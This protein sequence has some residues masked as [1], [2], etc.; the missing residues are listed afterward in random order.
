MKRTATKPTAEAVNATPAILVQI[1]GLLA[2]IGKDV[3]LLG[4]TH[5]RSRDARLVAQGIERACREIATRALDYAGVEQGEGIAAVPAAASAP[6]PIAAPAATAPLAPIPAAAS[7]P[8]HQQRGIIDRAPATPDA[9]RHPAPV[10]RQ[11]APSSGAENEGIPSALTAD[12]TATGHTAPTHD[13]QR[14]PAQAQD[15]QP[16]DGDDDHSEGIRDEGID[17]NAKAPAAPA[18]MMH[19]LNHALV[20]AL[21]GE[22]LEQAALRLTRGVSCSY[23]GLAAQVLG[24]A[25][26]GYL[27]AGSQVFLIA[28]DGK[29]LGCVPWSATEIGRGD[30]AQTYFL[31]GSMTPPRAAMPDRFIFFPPGHSLRNPIAVGPTVQNKSKLNTPEGVEWQSIRSNLAREALAACG[32]A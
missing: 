20:A 5:H 29:V 21:D 14:Q 27:S 25:D 16:V 32:F 31:Y 12:P 13:A 11:P 19:N 7:V 10:L 4:T 2:S 3:R 24:T 22:S 23:I 17:E 18:G 8:A 26:K 15:H 6:A 28:R 30:Q 9:A 1:E